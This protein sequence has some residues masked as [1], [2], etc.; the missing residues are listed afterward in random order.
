MHTV[1]SL[2]EFRDMVAEAFR[3]KRIRAP[4]HFPSD[5]QAAP[6]I[7]IFKDVKPNDWVLSGWRSMWHALLKGMPADE[8]FSQILE[9]RSMYIC[10][11]EYRLIGSSIVGG[12]LPIACGLA[13]GAMT[14]QPSTIWVFIGDMTATIG[15]YH[16]FENYVIGHMLPVSVI[17]EDNTLSTNA[18]TRETWGDHPGVVLECQTYRYTRNY[19]HVCLHERVQF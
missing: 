18:W 7:E 5:E 10:S 19:P 1:E 13:M 14:G 9:G 8:L 6:L 2:I 4:V 3:E 11:K 12:I 15:L 17:I 16:E